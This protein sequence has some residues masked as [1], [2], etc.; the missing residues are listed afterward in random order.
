MHFLCGI[1]YL[2]FVRCRLFSLRSI[3]F[4]NISPAI[5]SPSPDT[6]VNRCSLPIATLFIQ[7]LSFVLEIFLR[8]HDNTSSTLI[9]SMP[10]HLGS[11]ILLR[12]CASSAPQATAVKGPPPLRSSIYRLPAPVRLHNHLVPIV[13][14]LSRNDVHMKQVDTQHPARRPLSFTS[15][16]SD[17][18]CGRT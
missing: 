16:R 6:E 15:P 5:Y 8:L 14:T 18:G 7:P 3:R 13:L 1:L 2:K 9:M 17:A 10:P 4:A 12:A 11:S